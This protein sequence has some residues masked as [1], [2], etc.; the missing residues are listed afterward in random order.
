VTRAVSGKPNRQIRNNFT[1]EWESRQG[2]I[3]PFPAQYERVG[4]PAAIRA[5]EQG[6]VENGSAAAGQSAALIHDVPSAGE[7]VARIVEE[8]EAILRRLA[9]RDGA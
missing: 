8:A 7:V 6:D 9:R 5:R 2:E 1:R 3:Q 4:K